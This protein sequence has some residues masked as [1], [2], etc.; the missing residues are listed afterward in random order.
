MMTRFLSWSFSS[1]AV[2]FF[3]I[4]VLAVPVP[5]QFGRT[6]TGGFGC[7]LAQSN[8]SSYSC[9]PGLGCSGPNDQGNCYCSY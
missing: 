8:C 5:L 2:A 6:S 4:A 7:R 1:L 9:F 3:V